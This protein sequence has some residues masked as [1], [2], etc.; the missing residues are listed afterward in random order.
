MLCNNVN[1]DNKEISNF[2]NVLAL[3]KLLI[4]YLNFN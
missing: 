2:V 1:K 3:N 4:F